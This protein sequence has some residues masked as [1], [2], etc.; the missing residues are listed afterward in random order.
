MTSLAGQYIESSEDAFQNAFTNRRLELTILPTESCNF[1]CIYCYEDFAIGKMSKEVVERVKKFLSRRLSD[2]DQLDVSWFGGEPMLALDVIEEISRHISKHTQRSKLSFH[3]GIT[4]N[5]SLL[6]MVRAV[7]LRKLGVTDFQISIDGPQPYHDRSRLRANATGTFTQIWANL[8]AIRKSDLDVRILLRTH[9]SK[10]N[11]SVMKDFVEEVD[12]IF[13]SDERFQIYL[14]TIEPL[15][16]PNDATLGFLSGDDQIK[17]V[18]ALER[19]V[20]NRDRV[21]IPPT[22]C[23]A[24]KPNAFLIR[25]NGTL[26]KCTVGLSDPKNVIGNIGDSGEFELN[27]AAIRPWIRGW[28]SGNKLDLQCP[29]SGIKNMSVQSSSNA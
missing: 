8:L 17:L 25:A 4:T 23:Y 28:T 29:Y 24:C 3:S 21:F 9:L 27:Q 12:T 1:R 19:V 5:G 6:D 26:G 2:L 11:A 15:G 20:T 13:L 18:D 10:D 14:K 22:T 16:G 7:R